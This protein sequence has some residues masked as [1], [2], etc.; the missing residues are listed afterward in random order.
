MTEKWIAMFHETHGVEELAKM[1]NNIVANS[2]RRRLI[3]VTAYPTGTAHIDYE[4]LVKIDEDGDIIW[5]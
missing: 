5:K 3:K 4:Q 2:N 1:M